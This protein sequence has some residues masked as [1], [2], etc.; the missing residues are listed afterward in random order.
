M[1]GAGSSAWTDP[2]S[3][4]LNAITTGSQDQENPLPKGFFLEQNYPNPFLENTHIGFH[5]PQQLAGENIQLEIYDLRGRLIAT[6]LDRTLGPGHH[7]VLWTGADLNGRR[8]APGL[9]IYRLR[10][11]QTQFNRKMILLR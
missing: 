7:E 1:N 11:G 9:Y 6:L 4:R 3:F 10:R 8:V 5:I 2:F